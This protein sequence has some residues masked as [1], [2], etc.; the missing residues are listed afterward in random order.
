MEMTL[1]WYGSKF[2]TVTLEQIRQIPG[3]SGVATH[4]TRIPVGDVWT[5]DEINLVKDEIKRAAGADVRIFDGADGTARHTK[6]LLEELSLNSLARKIGT[7]EFI[8][9]D[10]SDHLEQFYN[11]ISKL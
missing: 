8:S 10:G 9:S 11:K 2:D 5:M 7:V 1:R 6:A 4:L 3:V